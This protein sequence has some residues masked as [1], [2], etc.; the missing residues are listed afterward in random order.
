MKP[1]GDADLAELLAL[2]EA[3]NDDQLARMCALGFDRRELRAQ[4][5]EFNPIVGP[6]NLLHWMGLPSTWC[7]RLQLLLVRIFR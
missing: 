3:A 5:S 4:D 7:F 6:L 1:V 2:E